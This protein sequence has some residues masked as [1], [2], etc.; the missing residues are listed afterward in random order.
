MSRAHRKESERAVRS[1]FSRVFSFLP[2]GLLLAASQQT[3]SNAAEI[4]A[5]YSF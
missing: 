5:L 4:V 2:V 1:S 3:S